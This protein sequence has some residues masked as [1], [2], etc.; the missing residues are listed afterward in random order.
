M[1][2]PAPS[3]PLLAIHRDLGRLEGRLS[4]VER[5]TSTLKAD[6]TS[7][8]ARLDA[9]LDALTIAVQEDRAAVKGGWFATTTLAGLVKALIAAAVGAAAA[10]GIHLKVSL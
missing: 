10:L 4:A 2:E 3:N 6:L 1:T 8:I 5:E 9:K 7:A